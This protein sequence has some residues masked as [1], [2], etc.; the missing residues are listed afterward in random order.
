[1][2]PQPAFSN[3]VID[4]GAVLLGRAAFLEQERPVDLLNVDA[5]VLQR[6]GGVGDLQQLARGHGA[7]SANGLGATY[8]MRLPCVADYFV[9]FLRKLYQTEIES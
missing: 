3:G 6:L 7:G 1:M 5:P 8:F 9:R 4:P 2:F